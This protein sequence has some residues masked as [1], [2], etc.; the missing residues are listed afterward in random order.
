MLTTFFLFSMSSIAIMIGLKI[1]EERLQ[2]KLFFSGLRSRADILAAKIGDEIEKSISALSRERLFMPFFRNLVISIV[3][4]TRRKIK[5]IKLKFTD[6]LRVNGN[7]KKKGS[8][9]F[10]LKTVSEY[11]EKY[12]K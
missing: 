10:F 3:S 11:K 6:S 12:I 1:V 7:F 9:S 5:L 4:N 2:K 8:A